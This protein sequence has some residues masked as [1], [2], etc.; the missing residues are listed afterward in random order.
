MK[1]CIICLS[2]IYLFSGSTK[3]KHKYHKKCLQKY[4]KEKNFCPVCFSFFLNNKDK[5]IYTSKKYSKCNNNILNY[6]FYNEKEINT[7][8]ICNF[9]KAMTSLDNWLYTIIC[10]SSYF[11]IL[12]NFHKCLK[13]N[14]EMYETVSKNLNKDFFTWLM[15][16]NFFYLYNRNS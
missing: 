4:Y 13:C 8:V 14:D 10:N 2:K 16:R 1:T 7:S 6:I 12:K 9:L 11:T 15:E 5:K 3:C